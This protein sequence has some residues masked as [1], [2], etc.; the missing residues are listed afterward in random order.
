MTHKQ[1]N[2]IVRNT[3]NKYNNKLRFVNTRIIQQCL[4]ELA[5]YSTCGI[6]QTSSVLVS[7]KGKLLSGGINVSLEKKYKF[8]PNFC[9]K[10]ESKN[11]NNKGFCHAIHAEH[12]MFSDAFREKVDIPSAT[13]FSLYSPC[14]QCAKLMMAFEIKNVFYYKEFYSDEGISFLRLN[15]VLI[16]KI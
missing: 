2:E 5:K 6:L 11:G 4:E 3:L 13:V 12:L 14:L 9:E 7:S 10:M 15:R 1:L 16:K 8:I